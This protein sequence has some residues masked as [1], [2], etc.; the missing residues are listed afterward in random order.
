MQ[1]VNKILIVHWFQFKMR[2]G[3]IDGVISRDTR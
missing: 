3:A 2:K 1:L